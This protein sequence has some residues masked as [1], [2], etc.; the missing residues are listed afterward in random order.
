MPC[1]CGTGGKIVYAESARTATDTVLDCGTYYDRPIPGIVTMNVFVDDISPN[2][3]RVTANVAR[4]G[5]CVAG[6]AYETAGVDFY[7]AGALERDILK[8]AKRSVAV[9]Y[10][11][12]LRARI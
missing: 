8:A 2:E 6:Y 10:A 4:R 5:G 7:S 3:T 11:R 1:G 9:P 12:R